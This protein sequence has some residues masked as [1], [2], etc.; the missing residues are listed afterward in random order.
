MR[1]LSKINVRI[2]VPLHWEGYE[3][4]LYKRAMII[5]KSQP[6]VSFHITIIYY[7]IVDRRSQIRK[8]CV[9]M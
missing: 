4:K 9:S 8:T 2:I 6:F 3:H 1:Q 5:L 7:V